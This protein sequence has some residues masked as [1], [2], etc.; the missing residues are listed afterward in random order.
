MIETVSRSFFPPLFFVMSTT[1]HRIARIFFSVTFF[2]LLV[3]LMRVCILAFT[4]L[5]NTRHQGRGRPERSPGQDVRRTPSTGL[6][7]NEETR[8][9]Y[10]SKSSRLLRLILM[11]MFFYNVIQSFSRDGLCSTYEL[12][13]SSWFCRV[14][15]GACRW[16]TRSIC[17]V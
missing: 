9:K 7:T 8:R 4:F 5:S 17:T 6:P 3:A 12:K 13:T 15:T 14:Y 2:F 1:L 10:V 11:H 16:L